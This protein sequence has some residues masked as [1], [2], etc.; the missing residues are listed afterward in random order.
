MSRVDPN[1]RLAALL[2]PVFAMRRHGD[3]GI[4]DTAAMKEAITF[5]AAHQ[6]AVLQIL[7]IH[8]TVGDHSPYNPISSRAL[9]PA[10]LT[11]SEEAVPGLTAA[12]LAEKA[13]ESWLSQLRAGTVKHGAVLALKLECLFAA[14]QFFFREGEAHALWPE[15]VAFEEQN[16]SW[17]PAHTLF[18]VLIE[19]N[20]G[21]THWHDWRPE[22]WT[23]VTAETWVA[24]HSERDRL[25][26]RRRGFA[27]IQ[28]VAWR[29]WSEVKA[30]ADQ[31]GVKL[32][33]EMSF[34]VSKSSSDV[35]ANPDLFDVNWSMGTRPVVYFDT[36]KDSER[37]GQNWGLPPYRWENHRSR[38]F[39][40]LR[41]RIESERQFF[42]LCRLDHLRGYFRAYMFPWPGGAKHSEFAKL[43]DAEILEQTGGLSPRF[44][45]GPDEEPTTAAMNDLQGREIISVMQEAAGDMGLYAEI[46]GAMP[47]Y[48]R[49][50]ID[51]LGVANLTFPLLERNEERV[52]LSVDSYRPLSLV[53]YA[54]HDH[55][56]LAAQ[57]SRLVKMSADNAGSAEAKDLAELLKFAGWQGD[58]PVELSAELLADLQRSLFATPC[59]LAGLMSSDLLGIPQ[60]FNLPG[61]FGSDTWNERLEHSWAEYEV[62]TVYGP[63]IKKAED[64]I[65][66]SGRAPR[67]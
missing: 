56:P 7:P 21:N 35:W 6:F 62:H 34:G 52:L 63:R 26:D 3:H 48:M 49:K 40:W 25:E 61:T 64:L 31:H 24:A 16:A 13:P 55:A 59:V 39:V 33:G 11:L 65:V 41:G 51:D 54:N 20:H 43:T 67:R 57:Y 58:A 10:L 47:D 27:F 4:G 38:G 19:E 44:L 46:M 23:P 45:P 22:H 53:S 29:Q 36:N 30:F 37:L 14:W 2:V 42:H 32:L 60:R 1:S 28:W 12:I 9:S 17:L 8:E 15:F 50:A 66:E 5:C 18:R